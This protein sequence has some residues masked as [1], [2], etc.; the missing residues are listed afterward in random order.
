MV[1]HLNT[2]NA[3]ESESLV[4]CHISRAVQPLATVPSSKASCEQPQKGSWA[5]PEQSKL[6]KQRCRGCRA[7]ISASGIPTNSH[8]CRCPCAAL[9]EWC[10]AI[11]SFG[12][13]QEHHG[14]K[15]ANKNSLPHTLKSQI[16]FHQVYDSCRDPFDHRDCR[17][18]YSQNI[19]FVSFLLHI[20]PPSF[21]RK[22]HGFQLHL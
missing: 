12:D 7:V 1:S 6:C 4:R 18:C 15:Q 2:S 13:Q 11:V 22:G 5:L 8:V 10:T 20:I 17:L 3:L 19:V 21:I 16:P 14:R 9:S